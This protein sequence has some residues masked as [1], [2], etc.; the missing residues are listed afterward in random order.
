MINFQTILSNEWTDFSE[1]FHLSFHQ[2][3]V[4]RHILDCHTERLGFNSYECE[5]CGYIELYYNS[6]RDRNCPMC[7][8]HQREEWIEKFKSYLLPIHYFHV[9]FTVPSELNGIFFQNQQKL[10]KLLFDAASRALLKATSK[11]YGKIGFTCILHTWGQT[12][13][14]HPHLHCIVTGGGLTV[15]DEGNHVFKKCHNTFLVSH[16]VLSKLFKGIF[17]ESL[18]NLD[19]DFFNDYASLANPLEFNHLINKLYKKFWIVYL[20]KPFGNN[21][22]VLEYIGRYSHRVAI[23]N[24]RIL[25]YDQNLHTVSFSYKDYHDGDKKKKMTLSATEFLRRFSMHIL[26]PK[27]MKIRHFGLMSN[28]TRNKLIPLCKSLLP[29]P[30]NLDTTNSPP[31]VKQET[32]TTFVSNYHKCSKCGGHMVLSLFSEKSIFHYAP[33]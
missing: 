33:T 31:S 4:F 3:K 18:K 25:A 2:S 14:Y 29:Q 1:N 23:S 27:F 21:E 11:K 22:A 20:K 6:C 30:K 28:S 19:L 5:D 13:S 7:Q 17:L 32:T 15:D 8:C 26:P 16:K 10:Y 12:L 9:V 24:N